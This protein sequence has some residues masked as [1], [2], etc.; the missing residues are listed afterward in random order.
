MCT[1]VPFSA[2]VRSRTGSG[3]KLWF[4]T[5]SGVSRWD[6]ANRAVPLAPP[7]VHLEAVRMFDQVVPR[8]QLARLQAAASQ[9]SSNNRTIVPSLAASRDNTATTVPARAVGG[10]ASAPKTERV[11]AS[12]RRHKVQSGETP[13]AIARRYNVKLDALLTA[14]PSLNPKRMQVG[15]SLVIPVR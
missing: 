12:T 7:L 3:V 4:G 11:S 2:V 15:Q 6:P 10:T 5:R 9:V 13:V 1:V 14:N 8:D